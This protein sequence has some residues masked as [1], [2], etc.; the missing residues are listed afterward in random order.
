[1]NPTRISLRVRTVQRAVLAIVG[2]VL[3]FVP[4][5]SDAHRKPSITERVARIQATARQEDKIA[6]ERTGKPD[7][8]RAPLKVA[9]WWNNWRDYWNDWPNRWYN[10]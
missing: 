7:A 5:Q 10:W 1:M 9:Q 6:E 2:A 3:A 4:G 8:K